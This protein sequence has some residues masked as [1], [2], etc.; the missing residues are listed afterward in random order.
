MAQQI[1]RG[2][3]AA[4][5]EGTQSA[6]GAEPRPPVRMPQPAR[7]SDGRWTDAAPNDAPVTIEVQ[8]RWLR[9]ADGSNWPFSRG[10]T[11]VASQVPPRSEIGDDLNSHIH[12]AV[13]S[14]GDGARL[15]ITVE[16]VEGAD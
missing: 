12:R 13:A 7:D 14:F 16:R 9:S 3:G 15:R 2:K 10:G 4:V 1:I 5:V 6:R 11:V 8:T